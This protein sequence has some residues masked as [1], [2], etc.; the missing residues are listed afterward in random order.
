[1]GDIII[2]EKQAEMNQ[3]KAWLSAGTCTLLALTAPGNGVLTYTLAAMVAGLLCWCV[4]KLCAGKSWPKWMYGV[5]LVWSI[6][7]ILYVLQFPTAVWDTKRNIAIPLV[8]FLL[9]LW[10]IGRGIRVNMAAGAVL[11]W[12]VAAL[13]GGI[14]LA[15]A[16]NVIPKFGLRDPWEYHFSAVPA[17][18]L[19]A[20]LGL[21][22]SGADKGKGK[23]FVPVLAGGL[24]AAFL[25][26]GNMMDVEDGAP[27]FVTLSRSVEL[28]GKT[29]RLESVAALGLTLGIYCA[30]S[31]LVTEAVVCIEKLGAKKYAAVVVTAAVVVLGMLCK[32]TISGAIA[33]IGSLICWVFLPLLTQLVVG[34]KK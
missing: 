15:S 9:A 31:L 25:V 3:L 10:G 17:L 6:A 2:M 7:A 29:L 34:E 26:R 27:G 14:L 11:L 5:R 23:W 24:A 12:F 8:L 22:S 1:M 33:A 28:F 32:I 20:L 16:E 30:V 21:M 13:L 18:L 4:N 19:P